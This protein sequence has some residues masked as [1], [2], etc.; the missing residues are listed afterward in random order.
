MRAGAFGEL[1]HDRDAGRDA[2][3]IEVAFGLGIQIQ[4]LLMQIVAAIGETVTC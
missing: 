4:R 3:P 1:A 2:E